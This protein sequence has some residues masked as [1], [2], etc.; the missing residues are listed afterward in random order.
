MKFNKRPEYVD[1]ARPGGMI[2]TMF[3]LTARRPRGA[4]LLHKLFDAS[5][6]GSTMYI[7][8]RYVTDVIAAVGGRIKFLRA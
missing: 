1:V 5:W 7:D 4:R 3:A 8:H 6:L 2:G